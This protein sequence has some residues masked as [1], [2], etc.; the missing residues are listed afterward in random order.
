MERSN[1]SGYRL[2]DIFQASTWGGY[3]L[4]NWL[5]ASVR[6]IYTFR[7]RIHGDFNKFNAR[8]GPMDFPANH[9]GQYWDIGIGVNAS[10][11]SGKFAGNHFAFEW[12]QPLRDDVNGFQLE[13][14]GALSAT[15]HYSF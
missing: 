14:E 6:G 7:D 12:V 4:S 3:Q 2:G 15:W 1:E 11:P 8:I 9:G 10:V 5:A 13:R